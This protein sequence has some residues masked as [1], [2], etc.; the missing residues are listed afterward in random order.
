VKDFHTPTYLN[1]HTPTKAYVRENEE[2][3]DNTV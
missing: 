3:S 2:Y 1:G